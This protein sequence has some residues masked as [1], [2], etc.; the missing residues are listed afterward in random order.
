MQ[1]PTCRFMP[2]IDSDDVFGLSRR[3]G[4]RSPSVVIVPVTPPGP[5]IELAALR[6]LYPA[7]MIK[8]PVA[9]ALADRWSSGEISRDDPVTI[10]ARNMTENDLPSPFVP[11]YRATTEELCR[12][13]ISRSDNVA[14]N[15]LIDVLGRERITAFARARGLSE[16]YVGRKLS[17]SLPLIA[18]PAPRGA[19]RIRQPTRL[20][21]SNRSPY[22]RSPAPMRY[23][24]FLLAQGVERLSLPGPRARGPVPRTRRAR[25]TRVATT[26]A[27]STRRRDGATW[28]S[29]IRRSE[30]GTAR[31]RSAPS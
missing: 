23:F 31:R 26:A 7:S 18:D 1:V 15:T 20:T 19:T 29:C 17:G 12:L 25:R 27:F 9:A 21:C 5:R 8:V 14:T 16:T 22:A 6:P 10:D 30:S 3:S 11:G 13:M 28:S 24:E 4:L 2:G